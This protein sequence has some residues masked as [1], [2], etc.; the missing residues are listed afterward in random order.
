MGLGLVGFLGLY[1]S[2]YFL[3]YQHNNSVIALTSEIAYQNLI[4]GAVTK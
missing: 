2:Y 3:F 4:I 1:I